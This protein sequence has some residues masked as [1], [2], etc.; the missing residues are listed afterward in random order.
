MDYYINCNEKCQYCMERDCPKRKCPP[1]TL[2]VSE[3]KQYTPIDKDDRK[4][5]EKPWDNPY[6]NL[7]FS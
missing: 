6:K 2:F 7:L 5:F 3:D 1:K 4:N